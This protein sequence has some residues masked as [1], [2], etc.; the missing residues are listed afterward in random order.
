MARVKITLFVLLALL[1]E[2]VV[3]QF[4]DD[5]SD[6]NFTG[7]PAWSGDIAKFAVQSGRLRLSALAANGDAYLSTPSS[8]IQN[9]SWECY[10]Q[11]DFNPSSTNFVRVFI[12]ADKSNLNDNVRGYFVMAGNT[13]DEISLYGQDGSSSTKIIDGLD[14][15]LNAA[16]VSVRIKVTRD[17]Q[18]TWQL[19]SD[20]GAAGIYQL[21]GTGTDK[22]YLSSSFAGIQ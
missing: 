11:M 17:S 2:N 15:R 22:T 4:A 18:S 12:V 21:E 13:T 16:A 5:F 1:S 14:G 3:G 10:I 7:Q 6:G 20:T 9:G 19:F 8:A